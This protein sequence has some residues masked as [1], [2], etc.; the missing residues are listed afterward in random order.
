M[1]L[2]NRRKP[3]P[4][5]MILLFNTAAVTFETPICTPQISFDVRT[6]RPVVCRNFVREALMELTATI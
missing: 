5:G 2:G 1:P 3:I 6:E 4:E